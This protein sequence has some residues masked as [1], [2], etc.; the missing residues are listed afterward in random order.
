MKYFILSNLHFS[1]F[2][3]NSV[4]VDKFHSKR[5]FSITF[6]RKTCASILIYTMASDYIF[7]Y[8]SSHDMSRAK[9]FFF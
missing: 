7:T 9:V 5:V 4:E 1:E 2:E 8:S 6:N 3:Q